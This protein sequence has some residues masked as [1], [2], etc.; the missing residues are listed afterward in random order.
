MKK[1]AVS[2]PQE[3]YGSSNDDNKSWNLIGNPY[4]SFYDIRDIVFGSASIIVIWDGQGYIPLSIKDDSYS[5]RPLEAF[6][7]QK[8]DGEEVITFK[9]EGRR[10]NAESTVF[11]ALRSISDTDRKVLNL[12]LSGETYTDRARIVINPSAQP[13]Y[14]MNNDAVKW[15]SSNKEIPQFYTLG[16]EGK[17][18]AINE[19]PLGTGSVPVGLY[20]GQTGIYTFEKVEDEIWEQVCLLDKYENK[21]VDLC[22]D[23]YSFHADKGTV[24]DRFEIRFGIPTSNLPV[25]S[26]TSRVRTEGH[27]LHIEVG[28]K[29][30]VT[31]YTA[32]GI[33]KYRN[34]IE[35]G[36]TAIHLESGFYLVRINETTHKVIIH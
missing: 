24:D 3:Y 7:V 6:F 18:Y 9:P 2:I 34:R 25:T 28:E 23:S 19:R 27:T 16:G 26:T 31:I 21:Q 15:M 5:L 11:Y 4:L 13:G 35:V 17:R 32:S 36:S 33:E 29:T 20:V 8:P 22:C 14:D 10:I 12:R 1:E 30:E